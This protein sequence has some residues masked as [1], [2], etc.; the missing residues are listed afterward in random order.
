M[1]V[2]WEPLNHLYTT[3]L[4][5]CQLALAQPPKQIR[6]I[7]F[8]PPYLSK[9]DHKSCILRIFHVFGIEV[10]KSRDVVLNQLHLF[11]VKLIQI[12]KGDEILFSVQGPRGSLTPQSQL[13]NRGC[14]KK[15]NHENT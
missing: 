14:S 15:G 8:Y 2:D 9:K 12:C 4:K 13:Q 10:M 3:V 7:S 5:L 11:I 1:E 6:F